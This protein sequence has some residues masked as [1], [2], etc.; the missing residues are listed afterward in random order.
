[1]FEMPYSREDHGDPQFVCLFNAVLIVN[2]S[3]RLDHC[4][5]AGL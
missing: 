2:G 1:M 5:D 4:G 3:A